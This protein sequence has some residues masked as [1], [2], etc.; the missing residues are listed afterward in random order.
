[1]RASYRSLLPDPSP[2]PKEWLVS[3]PRS[4]LSSL[5]PLV[6]PLT[7]SLRLVSHTQEVAEA[8]NR[9]IPLQR[10]G[11]VEDIANAALFFFSPAAKWITGS[12]LVVDGGAVRS[13]SS[14]SLCFLF[15]GRTALTRKGENSTISLATWAGSSTPRPSFRERRV[16]CRRRGDCSQCRMC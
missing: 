5:L 14:H 8:H 13:L 1:M 12:N 7:A 11:G 15:L 16:S 10:M 4:A 9:S 6:T 3:S 2:E